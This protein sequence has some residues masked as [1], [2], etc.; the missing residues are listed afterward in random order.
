MP[1]LLADL[2]LK[3]E[4]K[5]KGNRL[6]FIAIETFGTPRRLAL[7]IE[8]L[9]KKQ[10]DIMEDM[11]G[12]PAEIA[13][14]ADN[15]PT[16]AAIGFAKKCGAG[17]ENLKIRTVKGRNFVCASIKRK[18]IVTEKLLARLFPE[19]ISSIY[20][21]LAMRWGDSDFKFI[22]PIHWIVALC[23]NKI[24]KFEIAGITAS[25][26]TKGHRFRSEPATK[27]RGSSKEQWNRGVQPQVP[28]SN[29]NKEYYINILRKLDVVV[30]Q[31][32]RKEQ[33]RKL[34]EEAAEKV[35]GKALIEDDLLT[36]VT[37]LV[38]KPAVFVC[39]FKPEFLSLP[40]EVLITSMKKNQKY[41]PILDD[42]GKLT[43][44]F[45]LVTNNCKNKGVI[46]GNRRVISARLTD[47]IF[48]FNEDKKL[49]LR[50]R[51]PDLKRVEYFE[52]LGTMYDK[53]ERVK[54]LAHN[55]ARHLKIDET[56]IKKTQAA[57]ELL[58]ADLTTHMVFEFPELQGIMGGEYALASGEDMDVARAILEHY[59]P[60]FAGDKLPETVPGTI[61]S[62]ADKIDSL[63]GCFIIGKIPTGSEDPYGLRRAAYGIIKIILD[64]KLDILL[65][66]MID[67]SLR[68][69]GKDGV[70]HSKIIG[71]ILEFI[72]IRLKAF[73]L[74][75]NL[76]TDVIDSALAG[77]NDILEA[78][79]TA[80]AIIKNRQADWFSGIAATESRISRIAK[81]VK[82]E[83]IIDADF[84]D[85]EEKDLHSIYL[86]VN[87]TV[88]EKI[89]SGDYDGA[90]EELSKLTQPVENFFNKVLVMHE[91]ERIKMNRLALLKAIEKTFLKVADF[92]KLQ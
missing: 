4:E 68:I 88:S 7:L 63:V 14:G 21:P 10:P 46:D 58:K 34:V 30:D 76:P 61:V 87:W 43:S 55:L 20:L 17:V 65:D 90:L 23:G 57:A 1:G 18:G 77:F 33:I 12:P 91:D 31:D 25:N 15:K 72:G 81:D 2:K 66:E 35:K 26:L 11:Q 36:E 73:F 71:Q 9:P 67:H 48:F 50:S 49:P 40:K 53:T 3:A 78:R 54:Q 62:L 83:Q 37:Y 39:G 80:L 56:N 75:E 8:G 24:V 38:E 19:I 44:K 28:L 16:Q 27:R 22:R 59:L 92:T 74:E 41:F 29:P 51:I 82:R 79:D 89:N 6:E 5:L 60:R 84:I 13:F 52:K 45:V 64:K 86:T 32:E 70:G 69:Y 42:K 85:Q 47:A